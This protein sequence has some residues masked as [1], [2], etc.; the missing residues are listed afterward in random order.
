MRCLQ[1]GDVAEVQLA[2][3]VI[4]VFALASEVATTFARPALNALADIV[5]N[6]DLHADVR[7]EAACAL[8]LV[9]YVA[10]R[11]GH[12]TQDSIT[13]TMRVLEN[14]SC[15]ALSSVVLDCWSLL[16]STL[17]VEAQL[18]LVKQETAFWRAALNSGDAEARASAWECISLLYCRHHKDKAVAVIEPST[19]DPLCAWL[20]GKEYPGHHK[21]EL[22]AHYL[23][24]I[25]KGFI[26]EFDGKTGGRGDHRRW[27]AEHQSATSCT[28]SAGP[29][30][31]AVLSHS[32][33]SDRRGLKDEV[34]LH[35]C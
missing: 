26:P 28:W 29:G 5:R 34:S 17:L 8:S 1:H 11:R 9:S 30:S 23:A 27:L 32:P 15:A 20:R 12:L 25:E 19:A 33:K 35:C 16:V 13:S 4:S 21:V 18:V 10:S 7:A 3:H 2:C 24:S 6:V 14:V 31:R 22:A